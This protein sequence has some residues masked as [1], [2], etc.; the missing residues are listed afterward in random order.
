MAEG[1]APAATLERVIVSGGGSGLGRAAIERIGA[2]GGRAFSFDLKNEDGV[3]AAPV[4]V[5]DR[6]CVER[7]VG[8]F[9]DRHGAP[10]AVVTCAGI[11]ACGPFGSVAADAWERVIAVNLLGTAA[12]VRAALPYLEKNR[13]RIVTVASTLGLRAVSDATAYCA[14]KFGVIGFSRAL[15]AELKDRVGVTCLIPGGMHTNFFE[16]RTQQ[17]RPPADWKANQPADVATAIVFALTQPPG[18]EVREMVVC[19]ANES[20]WP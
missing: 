19:P 8:R 13:G 3:D 18:C 5:S 11:D 14:S 4:D 20:S 16:G 12:L 10:T 6:A 2:A 1:R 17:Y 7:A 9:V 15:A